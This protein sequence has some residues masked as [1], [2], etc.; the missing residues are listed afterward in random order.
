MRPIES[1]FQIFLSID[2]RNC[3]LSLFSSLV[4]F[5]SISF[6]P[7]LW[8]SFCN[9]FSPSLILCLSIFD[10]L[11]FSLCLSVSLSHSPSTNQSID[12]S[13]RFAEFC[14]RQSSIFM[15]LSVSSD[16][17]ETVGSIVK[18][19]RYKL[20]I[21]ILVSIIKLLHYCCPLV[22]YSYLSRVEPHRV[23]NLFV[24]LIFVNMDDCC[25]VM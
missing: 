1:K 22:V 3:A 20:D 11:C 4:L 25:T 9:Y 6:N 24:S 16:K 21:T 19:K 12:Q 17:F 23:Y 10:Y 15:T 18:A 2:I 7:S 13:I 14:L 5:Q 8:L